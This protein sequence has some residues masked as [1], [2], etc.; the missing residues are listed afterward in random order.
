MAKTNYITLHNNEGTKKV[1]HIIDVLNKWSRL[2]FVKNLRHALAVSA[3]GE[4]HADLLKKCFSEKTL[5]DMY[6]NIKSRQDLNSNL[7]KTEADWIWCNNTSI[8]IQVEF[9]VIN[10]RFTIVISYQYLDENNSFKNEK[11]IDD[12][13]DRIYTMTR[14]KERHFD[15]IWREMKKRMDLAMDNETSNQPKIFGWKQ[16]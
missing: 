16:L 1:Y 4:R 11:S 5:T 14:N 3:H 9:Q 10:D 6:Y 13:F 7:V 8:S 2:E 12:A 15:E